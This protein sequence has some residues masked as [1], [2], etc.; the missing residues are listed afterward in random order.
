MAADGLSDGLGDQFT[1]EYGVEG[2]AQIMLRD[3]LA[4]LAVIGKKIVDA[5]AIEGLAVRAEEEGLRRFG[6]AQGF[7]QRV[8]RIQQDR[9]TKTELRRMFLG[10]R[11]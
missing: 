9:A 3:G 10:V 6:R 4:A 1:R 2:V 5:P 11:R 7:H 8:L